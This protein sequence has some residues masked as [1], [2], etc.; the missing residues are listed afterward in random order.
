MT[1]QGVPLTQIDWTIWWMLGSAALAFVGFVGWQI[2]KFLVGARA[3]ARK[4]HAPGYN[5]LH[6]RMLPGYL[7]NRRFKGHVAGRQLTRPMGRFLFTLMLLGLAA[8]VGFWIFAAN[9]MPP[10]GG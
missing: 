1:I 4:D 3:I 9:F 6:E 7:A 5:W 8:H 2:D 10:Q